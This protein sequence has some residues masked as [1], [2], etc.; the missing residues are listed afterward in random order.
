MIQIYLSKNNFDAQ[1][2]QRFFKERR[3]PV[4]VMDLKKHKL[5]QRELELFARCAGGAANLVDKD[6]KKVKDSPVCYNTLESYILEELL[7]HPAYLTSPIVRNGQ[8][9]T[10]GLALE[11]WESWLA[12]G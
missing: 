4:Q 3:I 8:K 2:A 10:I 1:K 6:D 9:V 5:G 7:A 11:T 12:R